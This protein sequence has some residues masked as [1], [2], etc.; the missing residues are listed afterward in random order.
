MYFSLCPI[1]VI[2]SQELL[3]IAETSSVQLRTMR[4]FRMMETRNK[5]GT[6]QDK[7]GVQRVEVAFL[8]A[9][10]LTLLQIFVEEGAS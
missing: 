5:K 9:A 10:R 6:K 2:V 8:T 4:K 3:L 1:N 7:I